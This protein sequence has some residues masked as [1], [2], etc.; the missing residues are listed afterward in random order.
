LGTTLL[1]VFIGLVAWIISA[2]VKNSRELKARGI[3]KNIMV[4]HVEGIPFVNS[5]DPILLCLYKDKVTIGDKCTIP[6]QD[7]KNIAI[8]TEKELVEK[9]K[10]VIGRAVVGGALLGPLGAVVG[11]M[12]G[13]KNK[14]V[15]KEKCFMVIDYQGHDGPESAKFSTNNYFMASGFTNEAVKLIHAQAQA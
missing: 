14:Q 4:K 2:G 9:E 11:G 5:G 12:S 8:L 3:I 6:L 1:I 10:S 13:V 15:T 7:I